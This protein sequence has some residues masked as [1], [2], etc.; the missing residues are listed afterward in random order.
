MRHRRSFRQE[1][2]F[3]LLMVEPRSGAS[4]AAAYPLLSLSVKRDWLLVAAI[5]T[6]IWLDV[7][8]FW[9]DSLRYWFC[10]WGPAQFD[11]LW[12]NV[13]RQLWPG[14]VYGYG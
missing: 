13:W 14:E 10:E 9:G 3:I 7:F 5:L 8:R 2:E 1:I 4:V 12:R 11:V 6:A